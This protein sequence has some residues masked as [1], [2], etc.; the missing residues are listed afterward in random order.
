MIEFLKG[1][2]IYVIIWWIVVFTILPIGVR[3]SDKTE[4]GHA[5]GAPDNPLIL[6]K[7]I[8]TSIIAFILWLCVFY[9]IKKEIFSYQY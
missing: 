4:K 1:F 9:I 2:L 8:I 3:K 5:E 6:K 7:F